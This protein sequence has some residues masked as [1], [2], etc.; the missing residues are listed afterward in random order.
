MQPQL[1]ITKASATCSLPAYLQ[2]PIDSRQVL[3]SR[4]HSSMWWLLYRQRKGLGRT[5]ERLLCHERVSQTWRPLHR[6]RRAILRQPLWTGSASART[7]ETRWDEHGRP[8]QA[9]PPA[10]C[11]LLPTNAAMFTKTKVTYRTQRITSTTLHW[12]PKIASKYLWTNIG[13][14]WLYNESVYWNWSGTIIEYKSRILLYFW[15]LL[16]NIFDLI[17]QVVWFFNSSKDS[18]KVWH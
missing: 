14:L 5:R 9:R 3:M 7:S 8:A 15:L 16:K 13:R 6:F 12:Q 1:T 17:V 4:L 11:H 18:E 10:P 2:R